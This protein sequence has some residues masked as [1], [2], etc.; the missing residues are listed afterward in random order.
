MS[1]QIT[2]TAVGDGG[3]GKTYMLMRFSNNAI[4]QDYIPTVFDTYTTIMEVDNHEYKVN[5]WDTA[6]QEDYERLRALSYTN[7]RS[8]VTVLK[9]NMIILLF[10]RL[11]VSY[12]ALQSIAN[13]LTIMWT[14][15]GHP[16]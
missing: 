5:L 1:E 4:P 16:N 15:N 14:V 7:V 6:G 11:T 2:V 9:C 13:H 10:S 12:Y 3:V 8:L